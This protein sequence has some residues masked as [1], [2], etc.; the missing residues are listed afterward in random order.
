MPAALFSDNIGANHKTA[1]VYY[2]R[3]VYGV[4]CL[5]VEPVDHKVINGVT[6][7]NGSVKGVFAVAVTLSDL[8]ASAHGVIHLQYEV[9]RHD[10][11]GVKKAKT[12][13]CMAV[14]QNGIKKFAQSIAL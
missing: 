5:I 8:N 13:I 1:A 14:S 2:C 3:Q 7:R 10:I 4:S 12:V 6:A 11:V 9:F